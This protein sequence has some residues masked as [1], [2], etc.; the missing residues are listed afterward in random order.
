[1]SLWLQIAL[2]LFGSNK[3]WGLKLKNWRG[4]FI[5]T[6][7]SVHYNTVK[8]VT[9]THLLFK[10]FYFWRGAVIS[11]EIWLKGKM[12]LK[13]EELK[14]LVSDDELRYPKFSLDTINYSL[15]VNK[16]GH[17][18][19]ISQWFKC[20]FIRAISLYLSSVFKMKKN[21]I[22]GRRC[23]SSWCFIIPAAV[24]VLIDYND[25][26]F[27]TAV[28]SLIQLLLL[29]SSLRVILRVITAKKTTASVCLQNRL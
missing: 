4:S 23:S 27:L 28:S 24:K 5:A 2:L 3:S 13:N 22:C 26:Y 10:C 21:F 17:N 1:M 16:F 19:V 6:I 25:P 11:E 18:S 15:Y 8:V 12:A 9:T 20:N 29:L 14:W 7:L